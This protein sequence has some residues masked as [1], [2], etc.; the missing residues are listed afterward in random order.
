ML[1]VKYI[2]IVSEFTVSNTKRKKSMK[3]HN[4]KRAGSEAVRLLL[5]LRD[6]S[7]SYETFSSYCGAVSQITSQEAFDAT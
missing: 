7:T 2:E 5:L 1:L 6:D 3:A 4:A